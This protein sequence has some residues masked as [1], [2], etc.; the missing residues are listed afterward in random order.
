[1]AAP[2][3]DA[4]VIPPR[5]NRDRGMSITDVPRRILASNGGAWFAWGFIG[6]LMFS[7][8]AVYIVKK[9]L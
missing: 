6:G 7:A 9:K 2:T 1:M 3:V 8:A 4:E 5:E